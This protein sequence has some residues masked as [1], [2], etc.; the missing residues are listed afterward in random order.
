MR[1]GRLP[2]PVE[3]RDL[4]HLHLACERFVAA[5]YERYEISNFARPGRAC[6]HNLAYWRNVDWLG[7]GA[8]AHS[9]RSGRRWKNVDDPAAYAAH[10]EDGDAPLEWEESVPVAWQL[11]E[12]LMMGLRLA[13]GVDL[14]AL[15]TR[16]G[17]DVRER[18]PDVLAR[19]RADGLVHLDG[20]TL[21]LTDRG[22]DLA[23][24]VVAAY[25]PSD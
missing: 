24:H 6:R 21:A 23:N 18:Y 5:G 20:A 3:E 12:S 19:Q 15:A 9:H 25:V 16:H 7:V 1:Q 4:A 10:L 17:I 14:D 22:L 2:S 11:L 8:G 13:E